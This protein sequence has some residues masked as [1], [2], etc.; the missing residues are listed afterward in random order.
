MLRTTVGLLLAFVTATAFAAVKTEEVSYKADGVALKGYIAYDDAIKGKRP[1]VLVVHEWWGHNEHAR[2][3]ARRLA[4]LGYTAMAVDMYGDGKTADHPK[5]A[6][7]YATAVRTNLPTMTSR[8]HAARRTLAKHQT[9]DG[10]RMAAIGYCFGGSVVLEMARQGDD[11]A[12]VVSF[13]GALNT[14]APAQPGK[15]KA[16][17]LVLTGENDKM[18]TSDSIAAFKREMDAAQADYKVIVYPGATHSF[19][20]LAADDNAKKFGLPMAYH[21]EA[22]KASWDEMKT[23]LARVLSK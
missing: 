16:K 18:I 21:P 15:V 5:T 20:V 13:H 10:K 2:D 19:T 6:G 9:V 1:G 7:E 23:F 12:G 4:E 22:T 11:L 14:S 17:V 8:F 3:S